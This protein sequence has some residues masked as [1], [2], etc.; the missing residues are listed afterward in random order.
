MRKVIIPLFMFLGV[1]SCKSSRHVNKK[2]VGVSKVLISNSTEKPDFEKSGPTTYKIDY[3]NHISRPASD[4]TIIKIINYAKQFVGVRY[5]MGGTTKSGIDCSGLIHESFRAYDVYLPRISRDM[6]KRG[7][8]VLLENIQ[9]GDLVFFRTQNKRNAINHVGLVVT[10][11]AGN[12][13]FIHATTSLGVIISKLSEN[14]WH[15]SFAEARRI[16]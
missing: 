16:L 7:D 1:V 9:E 15:N 13:E 2:N 12:I 4:N 8:E 3:S 14:Y 10:S 6:A 5:K 11:F